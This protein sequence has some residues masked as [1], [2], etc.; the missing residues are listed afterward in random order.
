MQSLLYVDSSTL[1]SII[2][3]DKRG[4]EAH[5]ILLKY[6]QLYTSALS[7]IEIQAGISTLANDNLE[8]LA[9]LEANFQEVISGHRIMRISESIISEARRLVRRYRRIYG[10]RTLDAIPI[11]TVLIIQR[12]IESSHQIDFLTSDKKQRDCFMAEGL[13]G[14]FIE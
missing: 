10:L 6:Q 7:E 1:V 2:C 4:K 11:A 14:H 5:G 12:E 9:K 8:L 3:A 13:R